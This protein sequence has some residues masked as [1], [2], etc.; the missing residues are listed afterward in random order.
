MFNPDLKIGQVI[1]NRELINIFH[2]AWE[3]GIRYASKTDTVVLVVNNTKKGLP[4]IWDGDKLLFAGRPLRA[5]KNDLS[6]ANKR[7][8]EFFQGG[9]DIFLFEVNKPGQ[10]QYKGQLQ[11][12]GEI[13]YKKTESGG[14]YPVFPV[15]LLEV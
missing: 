6:G 5:G 13:Q 1:S 10:Y 11:S 14:E 15:K 8:D 12:A 4:N 3:G 9:K 7:L 2:C